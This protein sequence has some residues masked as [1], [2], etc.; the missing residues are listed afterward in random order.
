MQFGLGLA[1]G[2]GKA[3][4]FTDGSGAVEFFGAGPRLHFAVGSTVTD[5]LVV[6]GALETQSFVLRVKDNG[7]TVRAAE[8]DT[9]DLLAF[10]DWYFMPD[11]GFHAQLGIGPAFGDL[12]GDGPYIA[13]QRFEGA[14]FAALLGVGYEWFVSKRWGIGA[15]FQMQARGLRLESTST[16]DEFDL[17]YASPTLLFS[18]TYH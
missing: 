2:G 13:D 16:N 15:L 7:D 5:G 12:N 8:A 18:G 6:G 17:R 11:K 10:I 4:R 9:V 1:V 3:D 14:G